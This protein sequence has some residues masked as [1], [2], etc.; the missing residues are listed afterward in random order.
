MEKLKNFFASSVRTVLLFT[1]I[2]CLSVFN[3]A[4]AQC[5]QPSNLN[6]DNLTPTS[7]EL[8]WSA[9]SGANN[10]RLQYRANGT[11]TWTNVTAI[12]GTSYTVSGLNQSTV[13]RWR[14]KANCSTYSSI[15]VFNSGGG[16]NNTACSQPSNL[17]AV[18]TSNTSADLS[19]SAS[20]GAFSYTVQYRVQ[21]VGAFTTISLVQGLSVSLTGLQQG[22]TY[23]F[24]VKSSCSVYSS[25]AL[26][27]AGSTSG[28]G[29][30]TCS[31][32][33]NTNT[34]SVTATSA[35]VE[36][37]AVNVAAN[38]LV[39][40]RLENALTYTTVGTF[41]TA[42]ATINGLTPGQQYVWR[43]KANCSPYGSDVQFT[44]PANKL[45]QCSQP[46]NLNA[47]NL[48]PTSV[49]LSWS[50]SSG[51]NNYRL[52]YRA[53]GTNTWTNV[54]G[55][56]GTSY[57]VTG[58]NASTVYRW[59]VK[60]NC[61]SYSSIAVFNSGGGGNNTACSQ[62]S[63]LN[64]VS[65]SNTSADLS[66]SASSGAFSY[67][68]QYR[69]QGV[70][71]FT[72]ISLVQGLSVSVT[73]LQQGATY[74]FKVKSSCS[75]YSSIALF[76]VGSNSGGGGTSCS[77]PSN[78]NTISVTATSAM[79]EWEAVNVAANYLVEYRLENA[80]TFTTVGTFTTAFATINGL[81]PGQQYVWRVKA[82]C[83]PYGSDVQFTTPANKVANDNA[84]LA[85]K[86]GAAYQSSIKF[87][88]TPNP[89]NNG[90]IEI[91]TDNSA[92]IINMKDITGKTILEKVFSLQSNRIDVTSLKNGIYFIYL[93]YANE[94]SAVQKIVIAN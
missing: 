36:W 27:T 88:A 5:S 74:E 67:T 44:T 31:A 72:T 46:S 81:T 3:T 53:N 90:F 21:G 71:A 13:Y 15:A 82:N 1:V 20:S 26:F 42:F 59:R 91:N 69:V 64:A 51:A 24:K 89:A 38:Y 77:A 2:A 55:I 75:V 29:G 83:S 8:S 33:S 35:M 37:E 32:P 43:V 68:V 34:I 87:T 76:T 86:L 39:E 56:Q 18:S 62:P 16:G 63:N 40:Y 11:A 14:V 60:A 7:V 92:G 73:G 65:T 58:L 50:A 94:V 6:A 9:S 22:A 84:A 30:T 47:N 45:A 54:T 61:S 80:L 93:S 28:G 17:N 79:V 48:T 41:T 19:W 4:S 25:I 57:T 49:E 23:E 10:Y 78:T 85:N 52:Q 66:W 70:G 12:Q